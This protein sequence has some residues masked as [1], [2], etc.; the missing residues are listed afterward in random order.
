MEG[1]DIIRKRSI[2]CAA[3]MR[4][5]PA[6]QPYREQAIDGFVRQYLLN[7]YSEEGSTLQELEREGGRHFPAASRAITRDDMSKSLERLVTGGVVTL[8]GSRGR[9]T[10]RLSENGLAELREAQSKAEGLFQAVVRRVF[11]NAAEGPEVYAVAFLDALC[12]IFSRLAET[13]VRLLKGDVSRAEF[14]SE[15][16]IL[17]AVRGTGGRHRGM[18]QPTFEAG[19]LR[20]FRE[21]DP[22]YDAMKWNMAQNYYVARTLGLDATGHLLSKEVFGEATLYLDTNVVVDALE[23]RARHHS[24]FR[25]LSRACESLQIELNVCQISLDE[26]G[27][28]VDYNREL[29]PRV[30]RQIPE[31]TA[32]RVGSIFFQ[33]YRE[34]SQAN[35]RVDLDELFSRFVSARKALENEYGVGLVDDR[36]FYEAREEGATRNL[37]AAIKRESK[38]RRGRGKGPASVVHDALLLRWIERERKRGN[39]RTWLVTLDTSLPGACRAPVGGSSR[40]CAITLDALLQW[41]SPIAIDPDADEAIAAAF[42]EAIRYQLLPQEARFDLRDFVIFA[43]MEYECG[44]L[45][46]DDVEECIRY[47]RT[48]AAGLDPADPRDRERM[49]R[50]VSKFFAD[51]GRRYRQEVARLEQQRREDLAKREEVI[52]EQKRRIKELEREEARIRALSLKQSACR[53]L[54]IGVVAFGIVESA[55][56]YLAARYGAGDNL[57]QR[58]LN[59]WQ[60][61]AGAAAVC[62]FAGALLL[63]KE[64]LRAL[65]WPFTRSLRDT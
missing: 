54:A 24:G 42:S 53:R 34:R 11:A 48:E 17:R 27:R 57:F 35:G 5:S 15:P 65:G 39:G 16:A 29:I 56:V 38:E 58:V 63:G 2:L 9:A 13:Y 8:G 33:L 36:W 50:A 52:G 23:E 26:L 64:R 61:L 41:I 19:V 46:A 59:S 40:P 32:P 10:F 3:R 1:D 22:D 4:F 31:A 12:R 47:L 14:L 37:A 25:A 62:V 30:V 18:D 51:P 45:P 21:A 44:E 43:E 49:A 7:S 55:I 60:Y 28:V 20:F 6:M